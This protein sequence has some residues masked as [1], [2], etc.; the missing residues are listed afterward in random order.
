[1]SYES[2]AK[3]MDAKPIEFNDGHIFI[4]PPSVADPASTGSVVVVCKKH[5]GKPIP[6][7][8]SFLT[9]IFTEY[10]LVDAAAEAL[11]QCDGCVHERGHEITR[12]PEGS[13]L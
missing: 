7:E 1:M 12:F 9:R 2:Y 3:Y 13:E 5:G 8:Y 4:A 6:V 11:K 10:G